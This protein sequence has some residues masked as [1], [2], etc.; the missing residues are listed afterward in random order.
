MQERVSPGV[1]GPGER[2]AGW[3]ER[4]GCRWGHSL[5]VC[6]PISVLEEQTGKWFFCSLIA[7]R[8]QSTSFSRCCSTVT[9]S[10]V[11]A[12]GGPSAAHPRTCG[13]AL[14]RGDDMM[15]NT[16]GFLVFILQPMQVSVPVPCG[17]S[18]RRHG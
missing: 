2:G 15:T 3:P 11:T 10:E 14:G 18:E 7:A 12:K 5:S 17:S 8:K 16:L 1:G 9:A 4:C 13:W 6:V